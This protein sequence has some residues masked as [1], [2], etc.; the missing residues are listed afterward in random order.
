[1]PRSTPASRLRLDALAELQDAVVTRSQLRLHGYDDDAVRA[2]VMAGRWRA[3]TRKVV[4]LHNGPL[5]TRQ[6]WWV[7]VLL[8]HQASLG[9]ITAAT[10][11]GLSGFDD[12]T[13]HVLVGHGARAH[14]VA[15]VR[16]HVSR[17]FSVEDLHPT[18]TPP[19]VRIERALID[20]ASWET[21]QPRA[22]AL[23]AAGVQQRLTTADR[24]RLALAAANRAHH[25][26]LLTRVLGDIEGGAQSFAEI[27]FGRLVRRAGLPPPVRQAF[28]YDRAG[29]RRWLDA[30]LGSFSAEI[31]GA[32][33]LRPMRYWN[34]MER[35][36]DLVI[37][38]GKP[39]LRFSTMALRI[40]EDT[41]IAQLATAGERFGQR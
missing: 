1:M 26:R 31:D 28:R 11:Q 2:H 32:V 36:N 39:I 21:T 15:G 12:D 22:C 18:R 9:G 13:V 8:Q 40:A 34:D 23:L 35:Q 24:L 19:M 6:R 5:T 10:A 7:A 3:I 33:H 17:R 4:I 38:T 30:D 25:H 20:A 41:V 27:D 29:R 16:V 14:L 37:V